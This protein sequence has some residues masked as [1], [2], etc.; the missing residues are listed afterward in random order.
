MENHI[1]TQYFEYE[2]IYL[3]EKKLMDYF[4]YTEKKIETQ[5]INY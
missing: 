2:Q 5:N 3:N 1:S 4:M